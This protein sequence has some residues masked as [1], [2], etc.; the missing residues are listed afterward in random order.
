MFSKNKKIQSIIFYPIEESE[1]LKELG[2]LQP[3]TNWLNCTFDHMTP[4]KDG[5]I[6]KICSEKM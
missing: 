2:L 6:S 5:Q 4:G 1:E 3:R